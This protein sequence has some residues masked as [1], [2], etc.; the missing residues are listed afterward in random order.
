VYELNHTGASLRDLSTHTQT[1]T[2]TR[3]QMF[4]ILNIDQ[5]LVNSLHRWLN[6]EIG[7]LD[8]RG[9]TRD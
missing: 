3:V 5:T 4:Y 7:G 1:T 9:I 6:C 8:C 2:Y